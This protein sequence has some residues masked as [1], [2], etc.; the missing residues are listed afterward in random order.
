MLRFVVEGLLSF[1]VAA[2]AHVTQKR[3]VRFLA[4]EVATATQQQ[5]L[6]HRTLEAMMALLAV[7]VLVAGVGVDR[8]RFDLVV[9]HQRLIAAREEMRPRSLNRQT[10][11]IT[12]MPLGH[13]AQCPHRV[14]K[15]TAQ[16]LETFREADRHML[17]VRMRQHE[18]IDQM[19]KAHAAD[20]HAQIVHVRKVGGAELTRRML[21]RE[22]D[23]LRRTARRQPVL[24][25]ALQRPQLAV[26]E[27]A[28]MAPLQF[29]E[30][31]L[32][33]PTRARFEQFFDFGPDRGERI[34][35]CP[36]RSRRRLGRAP[37]RQH[38]R[39]PVLPP[40]L[41][42]HACL[43]RRKCQRRLLAEP[44]PQHAH[45]SIRDHRATPSRRRNARHHNSIEESWKRRQT[46]QFGVSA[47]K[48]SCRRW[49][50]VVVVN[51][52]NL[53]PGMVWTP[54]AVGLMTL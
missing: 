32:G 21:L 2:L 26:G 19:L 8:L 3:L 16:A 44:L 17:P 11:P 5:R 46:G 7:A 13:A 36:I 50:F 28:R 22:E 31:R 18:V 53:M 42:I 12:A 20:G 40:R 35:P 30:E 49:G 37:R 48:C 47:G 38:V 23:F 27:R 10:H 39:M 29:L 9:R 54:L 52:G 25:A 51:H 41:A 45:L 34:G 24:D 14:L 1:G 33:F 15:T 6:L 43:R 4:W